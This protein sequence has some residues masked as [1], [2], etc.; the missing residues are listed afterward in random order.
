MLTMLEAAK[1]TPRRAS[2][3][4]IINAMSVDVEDFFQVGAF[5]KTIHRDDWASYDLRV[6]ANTN[7]LLDLFADKGVSA[8]FFTLAWVAERVPSLIKRI[9]ADGHELASHGYD[10]K[11]VTE[12][13]PETF[14]DDL[15]RSRTILEDIGGVAVKGYRA[16]SFSIGEKNLW[17]LDVLQEEGY[18]Y[19][20][21]VFP[22]RHDHYG[23]PN[24][25]KQAFRPSGGD[26]VEIPLT[27]TT[28]AGRTIACSGG[29]YYRLLPYGVSKR[30]LKRVN[31]T[32]GNAIM[33]YL[34]PWEI[35]ADQPKQSDASALS[36]FR[37][38]VNLDSMFGKIASALDDFHWDRAD[39]VYLSDAQ[40][41][42]AAA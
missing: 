31:E 13:T 33:F 17:A 7:R 34:H 5:E 25:P 4:R 28:I 1:I 37:H 36:R 9:V 16:P 40:A 23:M 12:F 24:A 32:D 15:H 42:Q 19:S 30:L 38:Y 21:S 2:D 22:I 10:H 6:E 26:M 18:A 14:R 8:T 20:S 29:G 3:G 41:T 27:T 11:R 39:R 35:D